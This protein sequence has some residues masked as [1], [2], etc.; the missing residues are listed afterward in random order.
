MKLGSFHKPGMWA[1]ENDPLQ[2]VTARLVPLMPDKLLFVNIWF[3]TE[4]L[5]SDAAENMASEMDV[6]SEKLPFVDETL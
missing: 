6:Y 5:V 1:G 4:W 3:A 2:T